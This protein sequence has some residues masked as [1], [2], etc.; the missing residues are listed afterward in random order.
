MNGEVKEKPS[1]LNCFGYK[2]DANLFLSVVK[3]N[4]MKIEFEN[5][6]KIFINE[7]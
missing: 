2:F 5:S 6:I 4:F 1:K 7:L 3:Q